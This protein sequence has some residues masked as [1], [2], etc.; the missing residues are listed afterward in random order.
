MK[1]I[2]TILTLLMSSLLNAQTGPG[3]VGNTASNNMWYSGDFGAY[4]DAGVTP[5]SH[6]Q[7][8]QQWR[9]RSG[10]NRHANQATAANR[11]L[12]HNNAANGYPGL[13][14]TGNLFIDGPTPGVANNSS[15]TYLMVFRDTATTLGGTNDGNGEFILDR[16]TATNELVSL[17]PVTGN[18]Y[19]YQKRNN[20]GGGLGGVTGTTAINTNTKIIE[21]R[22]DY[23]VN[24]QMYYNNALESTLNNNTD[25]LTTPPPPRIGRHATAAN[26]G[27]RGYINEFIVYNFAL[28]TAQTI[29]VN[30][31]LAAKYG[32]T[33]NANDVYTMD[34]PANGNYDHEVAGIGRIDASNIQNDSQG[35]GIVRILNP[36]G[37]D[38]DEFLMWGHDNG[39]QQAINTI[40]VPISVEA[41]FD[42]VWRVSESN[43]V[44]SSAVDVGDI[45]M[46]WDLNGLGVVT[47]SDLRL[48]IDDNN[49]GIFSDD[50]PIA[51]AVDLGGG[52]YE[53]Q[54]VPG[55]AG[56]IQNARRFTLGTINSSQTPLPI[57]LVFFNATPFKDNRKVKL[58]WQTASE[59]NNDFFTI[60]K[61]L[62]GT[63]WE[64]IK[65]V[66]GS[67]N[68]NELLNYSVYDYEP[69][70]GVSYYRLK[71]TDFD[72]QF[73]YSQI[74][75]VSISQLISGSVK[76]Y[77]NPTND[78]ITVIGSE[79]ELSEVRIFNALGQ[80]VTYLTTISSSNES[81]ML[82]DVSRLAKGIY[83]VKTKTT[84]NS[85]Y[86][87]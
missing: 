78:K 66:D 39:V 83:Y 6:G 57:E 36:T 65:K 75:S 50:T 27:I 84:A 82:I 72:G 44:G 29:I 61:S 9:D 46:R 81:T 67:G 4:T 37:L 43:A 38:D 24:Y 40:D 85:V 30:N 8:I 17:K 74:K 63:D 68:S 49:N 76:I 31:Y 62:N 32:L 86:K 22:R 54:N 64:I 42:R 55:G 12:F 53:F 47:A 45:D 79:N 87:K 35:T 19:F 80:D 73:E 28:N 34:N 18:R 5:A 20:A 2:V 48:L 70:I 58:E 23:N 33:L 25:G 41:R 14:F 10:N 21:M 60:E 16:P 71:Q 56:G 69:N 51:G 7:Q 52:I 59:I 77:P 1:K 15:Y 13:R 11:P 3:G 26:G